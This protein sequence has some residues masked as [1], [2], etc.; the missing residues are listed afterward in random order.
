MK[1]ASGKTEWLVHELSEFIHYT[2]YICLYGLGPEGVEVVDIVTVLAGADG[3]GETLRV[4]SL[5]KHVRHDDRQFDRE[6]TFDR[7]TVHCQKGD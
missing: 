3:E 5:P 4:F 7:E 6:V 2:I 1:I